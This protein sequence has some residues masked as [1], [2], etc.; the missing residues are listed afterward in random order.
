MMLR[1]LIGNKA[2][3]FRRSPAASSDYI[4]ITFMKHIGYLYHHFFRGLIILPKSIRQSGIRINHHG[5]RIFLQCFHIFHHS[6][7]AKATVEPYGKRFGMDNGGNSGIES[8]SGKSSARFRKCERQNHRYSFPILLHSATSAPHRN[9][10]V[11]SIENGFYLKNINP[12]LNQRFKLRHISINKDIPVHSPC[13]I[14]ALRHRQRFACGPHT[15]GN[16]TQL[17]RMSV[18]I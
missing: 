12:T 11:K 13:L 3:V 10:S 14:Y 5:K 17:A 2:Y 6:V 7:S 9:F 18:H 8:L 16:P 15:S 1:S 4:H